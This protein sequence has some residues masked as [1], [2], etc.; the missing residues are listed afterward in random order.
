MHLMEFQGI[1][2][3]GLKILNI[4]QK[5]NFRKAQNMGIVFAD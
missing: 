2:G 5:N 4:E 3:I 1:E